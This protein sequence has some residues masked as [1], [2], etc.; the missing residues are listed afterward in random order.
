MRQPTKDIGT[1][2]GLAVLPGFVVLFCSESYLLGAF[3]VTALCG[4]FVSGYRYGMWYQE[5][6]MKRLPPP[7]RRTN[8]REGRGRGK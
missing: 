5:D 2:C 8:I 6:L 7:P 1:Y 3:V 4:W